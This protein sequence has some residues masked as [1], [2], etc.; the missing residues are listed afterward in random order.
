VGEEF[1]SDLLYRLEGHEFVLRL[2]VRLNFVGIGLTQA[3]RSTAES[4]AS[5]FCD[6]RLETVC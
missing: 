4:F 6:P 5:E 2:D 1:L 3:H